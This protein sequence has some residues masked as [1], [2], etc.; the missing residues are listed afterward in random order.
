MSWNP[1]PPLPR[2]ALRDLLS[3]TR[4]LYR[5]ANEADPRDDGRIQ[6][7]EGIGK[8]LREALRLS[9]GAAPGTISHATAH[10]AVERAIVELQQLVGP[11]VQ[12]VL[13][14]TARCFRRPGSMV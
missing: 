11:E 1:Y 8:T 14:A 2:G 7:L 6:A 10:A 3:L 5:A 9:K 4:M 13:E 12:A